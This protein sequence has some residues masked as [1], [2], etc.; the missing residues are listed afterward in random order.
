MGSTAD[1]VWHW[2]LFYEDTQQYTD[3]VTRF[4]LDALEADRPA[5]VAVPAAHGELL[6]ER[7]DGAAEHVRF[8]DMAAVGRNPS[9]IIPA[10]R[11]FVDEHADRPVSF[12]GEPIWTGRRP[13]EI[14]EATRHEALINAAFEGADAEILCPYD[15]AGLGPD[16]LADAFRTHPELVD[17]TGRRAPSGRYEDP[18][19]VWQSV[20]FLP[21][22]PADAR[23]FTVLGHR[24]LGSL[25]QLVREV[26]DR[27]PPARV[28][29][30][31]LA[32]TELA[33]NSLRHGGGAATVS[34]W[35][36]GGG[37]M[38]CEVRDSGAVTDPL[39]G[40]RAPDPAGA[41]GR[42]LWLVNQ[43]C[44]LVQLHSGRHGTR[45]RITVEAA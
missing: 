43:L 13:A 31:A 15:V 23:V 1:A 37:R 11:A 19:A 3:G 20:G 45:V 35:P 34:L 26:A 9:R 8:A 5:F 22:V 24:D 44:D 14:A 25:R 16:V 30:L 7:L 17:H 29:E 6:R 12:V 39:V 42:G 21:P 27:L 38:L 10:I 36:E 4:V 33:T 40:R 18:R 2:A 32:T 41:T 28:E